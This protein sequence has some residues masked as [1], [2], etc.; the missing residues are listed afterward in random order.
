[1]RHLIPSL[2]LALLL[3]ETACSAPNAVKRND[4]DTRQ[5]IRRF[6]F[7]DGVYRKINHSLCTYCIQCQRTVTGSK[8]QVSGSL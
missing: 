4:S 5:K 3:A 8:Q 2:C 6:R 1:M 7:H